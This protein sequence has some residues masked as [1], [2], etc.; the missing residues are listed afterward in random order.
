M[1]EVR[2]D[3]R[4][5]RAL[6]AIM[7]QFRN[8][9][10][11]V[12]IMGNKAER[13]DIDTS[14]TTQDKDN[15]PTIGLKHETGSKADNLPRRSW[16]RVPILTELPKRIA[17]IGKSVWRHLI[18][19]HGPER[20]LTDLGITAENTIQ[21]AFDVEG[22]GWAPLSAYT[23]KHKRKNKNRILIETGQLRRAVSSEVVKGTAP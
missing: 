17:Q 16:L 11:K 9:R 19:H 23:L 2:T 18:L 10:V 13:F 5:L 20:A 8:W 14:T 22:P 1:N 3:F 7:D 21:H 12:G 4:E 6:A 15:N